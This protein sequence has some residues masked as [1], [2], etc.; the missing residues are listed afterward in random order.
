MGNSECVQRKNLV[1]S[2]VFF[3]YIYTR[4]EDASKANCFSTTSKTYNTWSFLAWSWWFF[5]FFFFLLFHRLFLEF[6]NSEV[7]EFLFFADGMFVRVLC[8]RVIKTY[9]FVGL[10]SKKKKFIFTCKMLIEW[11][12]HIQRHSYYKSLELNDWLIA[13]VDFK[14]KYIYARSLKYYDRKLIYKKKKRL[15]PYFFHLIKF[16]ILMNFPKK[17]MESSCTYLPRIKYNYK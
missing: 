14:L 15:N 2:G 4:A 16:S 17:S 13:D 5:F 7:D 10:A 12:I 3:L 11:C 6:R 9:S 8:L 1:H